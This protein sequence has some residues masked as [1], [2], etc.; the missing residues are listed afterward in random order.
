MV[1]VREVLRGWLEGHGL[2]EV[3]RRAGVDRKTAR[4][5]VEAAQAAGLARAAG[6]DAVDDELVGQVVDAVRPARQN[7]H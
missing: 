2:R 4:R 3:A 6:L 7:G 1:E 5:Y